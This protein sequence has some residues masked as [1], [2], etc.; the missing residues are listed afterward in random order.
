MKEEK[1]LNI[2]F[3][4]M[5]I[6]CICLLSIAIVPKS[7]QNDTFY[8]IKLGKAKLPYQIVT[9]SLMAIFDIFI[10]I[11]IFNSSF[12][13]NDVIVKIFIVDI[14]LALVGMALLAIFSKKSLVASDNEFV[15][16]PKSEYDG[17]KKR[18]EELE[19]ELKIKNQ[20]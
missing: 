2:K 18:I 10:T 8:T 7:L 9:Y 16:I 19:N 20:A 6:M 12:L 17:L 13:D 4:I 11:Q 5:A 14:I 3:I 15:K 1:V